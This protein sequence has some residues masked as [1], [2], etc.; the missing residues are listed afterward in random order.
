MNKEQLAK[1]FLDIL[2][3]QSFKNWLEKDFEDYITG[4]EGAPTK[5]QILKDLQWYLPSKL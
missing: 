3:Q 1:M 5:E 2:E 4:E